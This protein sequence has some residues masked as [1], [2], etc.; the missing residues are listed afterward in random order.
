MLQVKNLPDEL[1]AALAARARAQGTSM[2]EYVTRMIRRDLA[3]P[4]IAEWLAEQP[5][6]EALH[7]HIDV[8]QALDDVRI[9]Y[10]GDERSPASAEPTADNAAV[11]P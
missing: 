11:R 2:S 8:V 4:T 7:R 5:T 1:H 9:D 3:R 10:D 6:S